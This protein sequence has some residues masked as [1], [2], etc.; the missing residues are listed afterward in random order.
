MVNNSTLKRKT[1]MN[2]E[3]LYSRGMWILRGVLSLP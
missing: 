2:S 1:V 3:L